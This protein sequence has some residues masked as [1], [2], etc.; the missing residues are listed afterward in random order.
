MSGHCGH[1][2]SNARVG[3]CFSS[4]DERVT[5]EVL[6]YSKPSLDLRNPVYLGALAPV[7]GPSEDVYP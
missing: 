4:S 7:R 1:G 6:F 3:G 5:K 2:A